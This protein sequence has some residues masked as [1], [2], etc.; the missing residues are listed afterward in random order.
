VRNAVTQAELFSVTL[1][2]LSTISQPLARAKYSKLCSVKES[3]GTVAMV[4]PAVPPLLSVLAAFWID[5]NVSGVDRPAFWNRSLRY[6][7]SCTHASL[8]TAA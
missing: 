4:M 7:S 2:E 6:R 1:P 8:G 3:F 5:S